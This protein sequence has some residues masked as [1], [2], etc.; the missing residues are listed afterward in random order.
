[1][2]T[3]L[4][5]L[6]ASSWTASCST[7]FMALVLLLLHTTWKWPILLHSMHV[8]PYARHCLGRWLLP[9]YLH[10]CFMGILICVLLLRLSFHIFLAILILSNFFASVRLFITM[11]CALCTSTLLAHANTSSLE[12][13]LLL[14]LC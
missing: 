9:Q 8:F 10:I 6:P 14:Y 12:M 1:M 5:S 11:D 13:T 2:L 3:N 7:F 4:M